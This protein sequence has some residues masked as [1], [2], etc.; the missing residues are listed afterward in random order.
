MAVYALRVIHLIHFLH[1]YVS[2]NNRRSKKVA[3][4]NDFT[5]VAKIEETRSYWESL[6]Q[7]GPLHGDFPKP[8]KSY[9]VVKEQYFE[10]AIETFRESEVKITTE[11]KKHLGAA[12]GSEDFKASYGKSLVDNWIDQLNLFSK[13]AE[14]EP[15]SAYSAFVSGFK[16]KLTY[17]MRT[18]PCIKDYLMPLEEVIRFNFI[19]SVTCGHI[20]SY[21]K[22]V[23]LSLL[24]RFGGLGILLF[25]ENTG[26]EFESSRKLSSSLMGLIKDQSV[27]YSV[28]GIKQKNIKT[29]IK[30]EKENIHKNVLNTLRNCLNENQLRLSSYNLEKGALS[31]LTSYPISGHGFD[32]TKQQ[33]GTALG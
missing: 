33:F 30:T 1:G 29:T 2:M 32:L 23:L 28:N 15:Q 11:D 14:S 25:H 24:T 4:A 10:N 13:V 8:F 18:A 31:W 16:G 19:P 20:C 6:Q 5:I 22:R 3:F 17:Y 26:I 21:G 7:V 12:I 9:L 27:L